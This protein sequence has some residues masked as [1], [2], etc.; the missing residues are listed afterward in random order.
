VRCPIDSPLHVTIHA[1]E[2]PLQ[3]DSVSDIAS[4][5]VLKIETDGEPQRVEAMTLG[6]E[7]GGQWSWLAVQSAKCVER[8]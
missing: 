8:L 7:G 6:T 5:Q 3:K 2:R 4:Y 1:A